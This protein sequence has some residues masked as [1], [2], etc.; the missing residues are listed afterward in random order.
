MS[1]LV[2]TGTTG[3]RAGESKRDAPVLLAH[4]VERQVDD[5]FAAIENAHAIRN[6]FDFRDLVR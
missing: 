2:A 3:G 5:Q 4:V 1:H 6:P